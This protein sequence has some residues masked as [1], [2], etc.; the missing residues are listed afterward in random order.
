MTDGSYFSISTVPANGSAFID[1][2]EG[3]WTY[4]PNPNFFGS[5][6][7]GV[8]VTDDLGTSS[9]TIINLSVSPVDDATSWWHHPREKRKD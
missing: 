2:T 7:F 3:N 1:P 8:S 5:D 4:S 9:T 6:S